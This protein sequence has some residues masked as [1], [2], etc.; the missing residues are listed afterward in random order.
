LNLQE[1]ETRHTPS[2][3]HP[4]IDGLLEYP[5]RQ[6]LGAR[7]LDAVRR[8]PLHAAI[9]LVACLLLALVLATF[10]EPVYTAKAQLGIGRI[11]VAT[12][13]IP[14]FVTASHDLAAAYSRALETTAVTR[15]LARRL[16]TSPGEVD[17]QLSASPVPES[18]VIVITATGSS[19]REAVELAN[20]AK[21]AL[22]DYVTRLNRSNPDS[23]RLL[24]QFERASL[25]LEMARQARDAAQASMA[26]AGSETLDELNA[27]V[28]KAQLEV[29]TLN[30]LYQASQEG[31]A[32]TD[33]IQV[34]SPANSAYSDSRAFLQRLLFVGLVAGLIAGAG[35]ALL[36]ARSAPSSVPWQ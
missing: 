35:V 4:E 21:T 24:R 31:Q 34:L 12:Y 25:R 30:G 22:T 2:I 10:R 36:R 17:A 3:F 13:S 33:V 18:P 8:Y 7:L 9:P 26:S 16:G 20:A 14:G 19:E 23:A 27:R 15:P 29:K 11:D 32:A 5:E 6:S 28:A 1:L